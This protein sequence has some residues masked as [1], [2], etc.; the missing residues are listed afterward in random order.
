MGAYDYK[1]ENSGGIYLK[2]KDGDS[3]RMR[4]IGEPVVFDSVFSKEGEPDKVSTRYAW[5]VYNHDEEKVQ[6]FQGSATVFSAIAAL[7]KDEDWGDP[8]KYDIKVSRE[9][10]GAS[11][12]RYSVSP[13][14]KSKDLPEEMEEL[15]V[16]EKIAASPNNQRVDLLSNVVKAGKREEKPEEQKD[17]VIDDVDEGP[18]NLDDIPF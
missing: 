10:S 5:P 16:I 3:V 15:D 13:S 11:D 4:I 8:E 17:V 1:P 12:T 14:P 18:V 2:L 9:G 6:V 7:A